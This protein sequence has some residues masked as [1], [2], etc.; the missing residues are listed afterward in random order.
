MKTSLHWRCAA[1]C[2]VDSDLDPFSRGVED[3]EGCGSMC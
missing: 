2:L 1:F 3:V